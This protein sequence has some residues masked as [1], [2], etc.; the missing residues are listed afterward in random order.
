MGCYG[1]SSPLIGTYIY[2]GKLYLPHCDLTGIMVSTG[3]HPQLALIQV[4]EIYYSLP[5]SIYI[6]RHMHKPD[7]IETVNVLVPTCNC[8]INQYIYRRY[9]NILDICNCENSVYIYIYRQGY[10]EAMGG[11][12]GYINIS[13]MMPYDTVHMSINYIYIFFRCRM[14]NCL[15]DEN[16]SF[17]GR[18]MNTAG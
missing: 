6:Y 4:S 12:M 14:S 2:L 7:S 15:V 5:R 3:N 16:R 1:V 8:K 9:W 17:H 18:Q 11:I 13:H 10:Y